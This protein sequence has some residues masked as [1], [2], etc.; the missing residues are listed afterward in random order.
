MVLLFNLKVEFMWPAWVVF[1]FFFLFGLI[2]FTN[3]EMKFGML[4]K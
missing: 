1:F 4:D 3:M 2:M